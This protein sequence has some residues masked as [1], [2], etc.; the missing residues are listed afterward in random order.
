VQFRYFLLIAILAMVQVLVACGGNG[1]ASDDEDSVLDVQRPDLVVRD[2]WMRPAV[3]PEGSPTPD[4]DHAEHDDDN[5][6]GVLSAMY[7]VI[8]NGSSQPVQLVA[9][10]T[11]VARVAEIHETQNQNGLMRMRPVEQ[12]EVPANGEVSFE[13][14]G[15]H[16]MLIDTSEPLEPGDEVAVTL[17][18]NTGERVTVPDVLVQ[19][20]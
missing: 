4:P 11:G 16:I 19:D 20:S 17:V 1:D 6:T 7:M 8:E 12:V 5:R 3:L 9:V 2:A 15:F 14:G 10:E 18:F 13:P